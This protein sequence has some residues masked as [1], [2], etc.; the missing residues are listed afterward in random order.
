M[1]YSEYEFFGV[2]MGTKLNLDEWA[3]KIHQLMIEKGWYDPDKPRS[4][5][6]IVALVHSELSEAL[7]EH[8]KGHDCHDV[9]FDDGKDKPEGIA[10]EMAD[11]LI[12]ILDWFDSQ[13]LSADYYVGLKMDFNATRPAR[14]GGKVI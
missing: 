4:F 9:Y 5:G 6:E 14:H 7:E 3:N 11:A 2:E 12:R 10:V 8:R 13:G 1:T